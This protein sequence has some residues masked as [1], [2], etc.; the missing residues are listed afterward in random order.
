MKRIVSVFMIGLFTI[1]TLTACSDSQTAAD[2]EDLEETFTFKL[3]HTGATNHHYHT[4]SEKFAELVHERTDGNVTIEIFPS[5]QLGNQIL[6]L[7]SVLIGTQDMTLSSSTL[8]ASWIPEVGV[9]TLPFLFEDSDHVRT[10]LDGEIG[11]ELSALVE[12][13]GAIVLGWWENGFRSIT[14]S[15]QEITGPEDLEGL[16]IRSPDGQ[17][18]IDTFEAMGALPTP[19]PFNELYS[20]LQ[21]GTVD[22]QENPPAHI[23]T[24]GFYEVQ[25]YVSR[26]NHIHIASPLLMN[27]DLFESMPVEYQQIIQETAVE[28]AQVHTDL[29]NSMEEEQW[30]EIE[31]QGM[32]ITDVD[33]EPFREATQ[34][35]YEKHQ[36]VFVPKMIERIRDAAN[37]S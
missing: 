17:V 12:E 32:K 24:Q 29:V 36:D 20:A 8:I 1:L 15:R 27:K 33:P 10:V 19:I 30:E 2:I 37:D 31:E 5:D 9:L 26:T 6:A 14:N 22:A 11:A 18:F 25:D 28:L 23:V 3:S 21:L 13:E 35:V 34:P 7:E 16:K 4:I